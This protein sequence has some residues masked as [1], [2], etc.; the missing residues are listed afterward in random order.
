MRKT[1]V[2]KEIVPMGQKTKREYKESAK[3]VPTQQERE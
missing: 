2:R 1:L 3:R